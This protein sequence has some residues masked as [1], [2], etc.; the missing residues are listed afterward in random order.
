MSARRCVLQA[1]AWDARLAALD[2][3]L[4][5]ALNAPTAPSAHAPVREAA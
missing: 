3:A 5:S 4:L 1:Y 2:D